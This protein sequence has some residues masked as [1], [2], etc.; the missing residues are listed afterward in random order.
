MNLTRTL[1]VLGVIGLSVA[2]APRLV[3]AQITANNQSTVITGN[4]GAITIY[5]QTGITLQEH[6]RAIEL[7][8]KST[9]DRLRIV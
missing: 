8:K 1:V 5:Q 6:Q 7:E 4:Q 2:M 9:E 3:H